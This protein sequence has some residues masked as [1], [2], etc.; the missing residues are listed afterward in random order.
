MNHIENQKEDIHFILPSTENVLAICMVS[1][2]LTGE[3]P[4]PACRRQ[5]RIHC[6][7][8]LLREYLEAGDLSWPGAKRI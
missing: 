1:Q 7:G 5:H 6:T 3:Q 2:T 4:A 8:P